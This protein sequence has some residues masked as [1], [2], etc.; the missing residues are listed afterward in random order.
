[1]AP[2][3]KLTKKR[4]KLFS[5][6]GVT[7]LSFVILVLCAGFVLVGKSI[8]NG[9]PL[10]AAV[11]SAILVQL[12]N[13]DRGTNNLAT[14]EVNPTLVAIAQAKADDMAKNGYFAHTSPDGKDPW[15][16]FK[17][18]GYT[19]SYAGEN[20]AIDF[21]DSSDVEVAWMN[22]PKHRA[23]ILSEHF[24]QI[25]IATAVGYYE[26]HKT[27]F[28]VQ[29]FGTPARSITLSAPAVTEV[30]PT[31]KPTEIAVATTQAPA[32][33]KSQT[34]TSSVLAAAKPA[35]SNVLGEAVQPAPQSGYF[36]SLLTLLAGSPKTGLRYAYILLGVLIGV[37]LLIETGF[38]WRRHHV[39][40][41]AMALGLLLFMAALFVIADHYLFTAPVI[42]VAGGAITG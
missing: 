31:A 34:G 20:L 15:Y 12:T 27:T 26:G 38:E 41:V 8:R 23:N 25:G 2:L 1:M 19:F 9:S 36:T 4:R 10:S 40:H 42:G 32:T 18:G 39:R 33:A 29:E 13:E 22:S 7:V 5:A 35:D 6:V 11:I 3:P 37:A 14:L 24:R 30:T 17:Q 16:W 28:V 21:S